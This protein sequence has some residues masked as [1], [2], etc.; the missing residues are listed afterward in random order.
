MFEIPTISLPTT[1]GSAKTGDV[2]PAFR[3]WLIDVPDPGLIHVN[4]PEHGVT[5]PQLY[6]GPEKIT[7]S[8]K[9]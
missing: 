5:L 1:T 8:D 6:L 9:G 7:E 3:T 4:L 2:S